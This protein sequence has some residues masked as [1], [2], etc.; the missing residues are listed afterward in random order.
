[1]VFTTSQSSHPSEAPI[2]LESDPIEIAPGTFWV[3]KRLPGQ[4]FYANPYLRIFKGTATSKHASRAVEEF[5]LLIDSGSGS[6][7]PIVREKVEQRIGKLDRLSAIHVN[8][9]DPD[10]GSSSATILGRYAPQ[11]SVMASEET[12][13]LIQYYKLPREQFVDVGQYLNGLPLPTGQMLFPVRTP[14]CHFVGAVALYDPETR[15]LFSGDFF[16]G[17]TALDAEGL[18]AD[19][20]DWTGIRAFHQVYMPTNAAMVR[21]VATIRALD[22]PV[23]IIA[24]QHGRVIQGAFVE[25]FLERMERLQVGIDILDEEVDDSMLTAWTTV[26]N[27][28]LDL[29]RS[30]IGAEVDEFLQ[31]NDDIH[32]YLHVDGKNVSVRRLGRWT[33][34]QTVEALVLGQPEIVAAPLKF[35]AILAAEDLDLPAPSVT[36]DQVE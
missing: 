30:Y 27:R 11:A 1:V 29:A 19:E 10:V 15:V 8:H 23:E 2:N 18:Y 17:L 14:F 22:P 28:V 34:E 5:N 7:F 3:G 35:E 20:S 26:L 31:Q 12:W 13:R 33:V 36:I 25:D 24:P 21:A 4:L 16:G 6:D 32:E 9:Q